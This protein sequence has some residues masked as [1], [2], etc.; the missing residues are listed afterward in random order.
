[1][2]PEQGIWSSRLDPQHNI[3]P[4]QDKEL[5]DY[6]VHF[7]GRGGG[8]VTVRPA[9]LFCYTLAL[10]PTAA[11]SISEPEV[12]LYNQHQTLMTSSHVSPRQNKFM[13][14]R[15]VSP[16]RVYGVAS[17]E[18]GLGSWNFDWMRCPCSQL[19][20]NHR[21]GHVEFPAFHLFVGFEVTAGVTG[22]YCLL[23]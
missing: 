18:Q 21:T 6:L 15:P 22:N 13:I 2:A 23:L 14:L 7:G 17:V 9:L 10:L 8:K 3:P 20:C 19:R 16:S 11:V 1:V 4:P 5:Q 12:P